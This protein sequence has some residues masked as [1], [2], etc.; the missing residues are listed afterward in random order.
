MKEAADGAMWL[1]RTCSSCT[2]AL[3]GW[4]D[5]HAG[6]KKQMGICL[7]MCDGLP[8]PRPAEPYPVQVTD[9]KLYGYLYRRVKLPNNRLFRTFWIGTHKTLYDVAKGGELLTKARY[10]A[11]LSLDLEKSFKY[12]E[13]V[14]KTAW[15]HSQADWDKACHEKAAWEERARE[16]GWSGRFH[17]TL[18]EESSSVKEVQEKRLAELNDFL[19]NI[20][21][22]RLRV[23]TEASEFY[24]AFKLNYDWW[25][26]NWPK[27]RTCH[28]VTTC[29][30]YEEASRRETVARSVAKGGHSLH[31]DK[32]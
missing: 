3:W 13:E 32:S 6:G 7:G 27:C 25:Q 22:I 5:Y 30:L 15:E 4:P 10:M 19:E 24:D 2:K 9:G 21:A 8:P 12:T 18:L 26:E 23:T 17:S 11:Q 28:R 16:K 14:L 1:A 20:D 31:K 29:N